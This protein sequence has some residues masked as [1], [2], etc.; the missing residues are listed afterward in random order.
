MRET[1]NKLHDYICN[2]VLSDGSNETA[3]PY[4]TIYKQAAGKTDFPIS[5]NPVY[6]VSGRLS[7]YDEKKLATFS[8]GDFFVPQCYRPLSATI[9]QDKEFLSVILT[10]SIHDV[11]S[12]LL[13]VDVDEELRN[14]TH[15]PVKADHLVKKCSLACSNILIRIFEHSGNTFMI[16]H[17]KKNLFTKYS[18][19]R[20]GKYLL[21]IHSI[22]R[23]QRKYIISTTG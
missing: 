5:Q 21:K 18:I 14:S 11:V 13:D 6:I 3:I 20:M 22:C 4:I 15:D 17:I 10:F 2:L 23:F 7:V 8:E 1:L 9:T 16:D 19:V 12:V